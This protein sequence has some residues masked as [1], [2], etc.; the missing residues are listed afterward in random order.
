MRSSEIREKFLSFFTEKGHT[1]IPS[2][3]LLPE[4]DP[5]VLFTTAGMHPLVPYLMGEKHPGGT[6][7]ANA[8]KCIRTGDIDE[9]GDNRHLTFFEMLGNWSLGDY[10]KEDAIRWSFEFLSSKKWLGIDPHRLSVSVFTGDA[11]AP[12]DTESIRIWK[13][14][15]KG[16]GIDA[17][18]GDRIFMYPKAKNWWGPAGQT[19]PC[20][21]DT[22]MFYDTGKTHAPAYGK[23]CHINCDCGRYVEIWN[24]VFMQYEKMAD[25]SYM[26]LTQR[27][28]DTGLGLERVAMVL[29]G[30]ESVFETDMFAP[31]FK[32]M[33]TL[34]NQDDRRAKRIIAD[35]LRAAT[36][37][38]ADGVMPSN[39]DQGYVLRRLIRRA[40]RE[41]RKVGIEAFGWTSAIVETIIATMWES[42]PELNIHRQHIGNEMKQEEEK[43]TKAL[44]K[45]LR[46]FDK[47]A[48][49]AK[50]RNLQTVAIKDVFDLY[51]S[52]GFPIEIT[53][54]LAQEKGLGIDEEGFMQELAKH[55]D[56]SRKGAEQKFAGGLADHREE[57]TQLHTATHLLHKALRNVLG[58]HVEQKGSNITAE[59][60]R[61]DFTHAAKMTD[62]EKRRVEDMV[63]WVIR[64]DL[65]VTFEEMTVDQAKQAGA[66]GLFEH[67]Y[68]EKVKVYTVGGFSKEI[69]GGPHVTHTGE[70][71]VFKIK[72]EEASSA[73]IRR[74]KAVL[75]D[76]DV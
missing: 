7:L 3:S 6:R 60:L 62:A 18:E 35:H 28:V 69:C 14:A 56:I 63:N 72:K 1:I 27:N 34:T 16:V 55:Q 9:V 33:G 68:G 47:I 37:I 40:M 19:G 59:R 25:G 8:Q 31:L 58:D 49:D 53:K 15:F 54:E 64:D 48:R 43:F 46:E 42:Y 21:P 4:N 74:I 11:D 50:V 24:D 17:K 67:K 29:Q 76:K 70:L 36:F 45:G 20:G 57:T 23:K 39:V 65:P 44:D 75:L 32:A 61:F 73:G 10:F 5:T 30:V 26:P 13:T 12:K 52:F 41:G 2:A 71:G 51:Q 66:I 22:E 38:L